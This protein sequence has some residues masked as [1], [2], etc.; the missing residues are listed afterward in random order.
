[1]ILIYFVRYTHIKQALWFP[2][3]EIALE[4]NTYRNVVLY[5][6]R[7]MKEKMKNENI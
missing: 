1:M 7:K 5:V 2:K 4:V 6:V 3:I